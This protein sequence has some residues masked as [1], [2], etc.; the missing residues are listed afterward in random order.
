MAELRLFGRSAAPGVAKGVVAVL[1]AARRPQARGRRHA[2]RGGPGAST[3]ALAERWPKSR[4]W[5]ERRPARPPICS[6]FRS[7]CCPMRNWSVRRWKAS[8]RE[9]PPPPPGRPRWR[10]K[11][12]VIATPGTIISRPARPISKTSAI[13]CSAIWSRA[14]PVRSFR[15]GAVVVAADLPISRFL[16]ID[17]ARGGA[18]VLTQRQSDQPCRH[19]GA[20]ERRADGR[21]PRRRRRRHGRPGGPGRCGDGRGGAGPDRDHPGR[22]CRQGANAKRLR[23][24]RARRFVCG[25]PS[26]RTEPGSRSTS[27]PVRLTNLKGSIPRFATG[28]ASCAPNCCFTRRAACRT[29]RPSTRPIAASSPGP[30]GGP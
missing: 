17:W 27:T 16:A 14:P 19:A 20:G 15:A 21:G 9:S 25:P 1:D 18:I 26:P 30:T 13:A 6:V 4:P 8:R 3:G 22:L 24:P 5:Q 2:S 11:S 10:S 23:T 7:R 28:S 12:P 29:R